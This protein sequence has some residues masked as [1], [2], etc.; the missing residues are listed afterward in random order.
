[1]IV[2]KLHQIKK[3]GFTIVELIIVVTVIAIL[4]SI[5]IVGY[6]AV[7]KDAYNTQI[8]A[9]VVQ[10]KD[11]IEA[12][13][14]YFRKYPPTTRE[15]NEEYTTMACLGDG[16]PAD[17]CGKISDIDTY[18]DAAFLLELAK[19]GKGGAISLEKLDTGPESFVGAAYG[20]DHVPNDKSSTNW[21]RTIQYA[22][23]GKDADC[24]IEGAYAYRVQ[25]SP[26]VTACEILLEPVPDRNQ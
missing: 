5:T 11:T 15:I 26:P 12:Y 23:K 6:G 4:A 22:L 2:Q 16:Y 19:I 21:G 1:M 3:T 17:Y 20:I 8:I 14:A 24:K 7:T 10:Y 18:E 25:D 13:K 9:G